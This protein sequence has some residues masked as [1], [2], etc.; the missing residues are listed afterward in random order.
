ML[1]CRLSVPA[2]VVMLYA[3][4][5]Y[6]L[7]CGMSA[8]VRYCCIVCPCVLLYVVLFHVVTSYGCMNVLECV[9]L[10]YVCVLVLLAA[11]TLNVCMYFRHVLSCCTL[12]CFVRCYSVVCLYVCF[13]IF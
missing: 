3:C 4:L 9:V 6:M 5:L 7:L 1:L 13:V 2:H 11:I 12:V 8:Y 10:R